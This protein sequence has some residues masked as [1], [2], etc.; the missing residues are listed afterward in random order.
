MN[1][2]A[3][4]TH[5]ADQPSSP[6]DDFDLEAAI[7]L[8][9]NRTAFLM[10]EEIARRFRSNGLPLTAQDFGILHRLGRQNG[11]GPSLLA[12]QMLRDKTTITRRIDALQAKG[13]VERIG[14]ESDRRCTLVALTARG[15]QALTEMQDL[16]AR[17]QREILADVPERDR[18][19][20]LRTLRR[21]SERLRGDRPPGG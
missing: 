9:V 21:I 15:R 18:E 6:S 1:Y 11:L 8:H 14:D 2:H 16:V 12:R 19:A 5:E 13:L 20:T 7:G 10:S 3:A 17:F 4:M